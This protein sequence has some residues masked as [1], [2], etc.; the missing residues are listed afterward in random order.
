M[1]SSQ[2]SEFIRKHLEGSL[3]PDD[4]KKLESAL[5]ADPVLRAEYLDLVALDVGLE[6][7]AQNQTRSR[8]AD[9][10]SRP[11]AGTASTNP[12]FRWRPIAAAAAGLLLGGIGSATA[13]TYVAPLF[14]AVAPI[15]RES[16]ESGTPPATT[17][18]PNGETGWVG[19]YGELAGSWQKIRPVSGRKM[20]RW[21]AA[22]NQNDHKS[23]SCVGELYRVVDLKAHRALIAEGRAVIQ[24]SAQFNAIAFPE[25]E[26]YNF[27]VSV[28]AFPGPNPPGK[29]TLREIVTGVTPATMARHNHR[30]VDRNPD[31]WE[32]VSCE[33]RL[34]ADTQFL[35]V[36]C[37]IAHA[38]LQQRRLT[39]D[40]HVV[41]DVRV[42]IG[43]HI[44]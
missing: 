16:F 17:G 37:S 30:G 24:A 34:P 1:N 8:A 26:A 31:T 25:Q 12:W 20:F 39:F 29:E 23:T 14:S 21:I 6:S 27:S 9:P 13:L 19:D 28:M 4:S 7:W 3:S 5:E 11:M 15:L 35:V 38:T 43:R 18:L 10:A 2:Y 40:G 33:L 32:K 44:Y 42:S 36:Q 22:N 41:D